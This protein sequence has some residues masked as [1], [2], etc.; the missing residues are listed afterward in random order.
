MKNRNYLTDYH[1]KSLDSLHI[2]SSADLCLKTPPGVI[3]DDSVAEGAEHS[4][5]Y[6]LTATVSIWLC[7]WQAAP[8]LPWGGSDRWA[9]QGSSIHT[10]RRTPTETKQ[11]HFT[12][13]ES[14]GKNCSSTNRSTSHSSCE[15][16]VGGFLSPTHQIWSNLVINL[17]GMLSGWDPETFYFLRIFNFFIYFL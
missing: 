12:N 10:A 3:M 1:F 17:R 6:C 4:N 9:T 2:V 11:D 8:L 16:K 7:L 5:G 14:L 13:V 15:Y